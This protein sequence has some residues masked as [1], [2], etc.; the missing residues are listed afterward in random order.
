ML[1][2]GAG[3]LANIPMDPSIDIGIEDMIAPSDKPGYFLIAK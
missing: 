3:L 1:A 2:G